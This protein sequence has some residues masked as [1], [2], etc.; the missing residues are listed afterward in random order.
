MTAS[1]ATSPNDRAAPT[2]AKP[3]EPV[4]GGPASQAGNY[5]PGRDLVHQY[6][7]EKRMPYITPTERLL[8]KKGLL[9]G[10]ELGLK[11]KFGA[12]GLELLPEIRALSDL[13]VLDDVFEAIE[14]ATTPD[15]VRQIWSGSPNSGSST[16]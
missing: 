7:E 4:R 9:K 3:A 10:I 16:G 13:Q 5:K 8:M 1:T 6:E 15:Q 12:E 2:V 11:L 14:T